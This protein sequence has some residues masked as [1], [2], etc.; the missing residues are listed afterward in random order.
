MRT[1]RRIAP[2]RLCLLGALL[3]LPSMH[4][5]AQEAP[6][7]TER[8]IREFERRFL[9]FFQ[10]GKYEEAF[11]LFRGPASALGPRE[12]DNIQSATVRQL[13]AVA[14]R[15]GQ[16]VDYSLVSSTTRASAL[17]MDRYLLRYRVIPLRA[18]FLF[19]HNGSAWH[20][21]SFSWDDSVGELF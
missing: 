20:L 9:D 12:V 19:Y 13:T 6:L 7:Q 2:Y 15:Y 21:L 14:E 10:A 1:E 16:S 8:D 18:H 3:L 4:P 5:A 17:R 11:K